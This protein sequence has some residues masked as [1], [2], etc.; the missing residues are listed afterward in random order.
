MQ[1]KYLQTMDIYDIQHDRWTTGPALQTPRLQH[2]SCVLSDFV[3]TFF[4]YYKEDEIDSIEKFDA[5]SYLHRSDASA[6]WQTIAPICIGALKKV[7]KM[8]NS[9]VGSISETEICILGGQAEKPKE[10]SGVY[11]F[12]TINNTMQQVVAEEGEFRFCTKT[13]GYPTGKP[14]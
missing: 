5:E 11:I 8:Q 4:G 1:Y 9:L 7:L 3:Y 13:L 10:R 6:A 12:D 14:G 2:S